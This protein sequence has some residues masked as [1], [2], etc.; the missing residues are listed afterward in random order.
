M[1]DILNGLKLVFKEKR[2]VVLVFVIG[3]L[4]YMGNIFIS[5][6]TN[7]RLEYRAS[8]FGKSFVLF[9]SSLKNSFGFLELHSVIS[10]IL[11]S[12]LLGILFSILIYK[13][14]FA[15]SS[16]N[17]KKAGF[18]ASVGAFLGIVVPGCVVCGI[19]VLPLIGISSSFLLFLPFKGLEI[20]VLAATILVFAITGSSKALVN[21]SIKDTTNLKT[22]KD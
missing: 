6:W 8:G 18:F 9:L 19:G 21:C 14:K 3:F 20:S 16:G 10:L 17:F 7:L 13:F 22:K 11:I 1:K 4:F 15:R 5:E 12:L 2:N